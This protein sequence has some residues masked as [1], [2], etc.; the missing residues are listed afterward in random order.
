MKFVSHK[1]LL[2][3]MIMKWFYDIFSI[4]ISIGVLFVFADDF[5][6]N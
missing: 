2:I 6:K 5:W 4:I 3:Y 1:L